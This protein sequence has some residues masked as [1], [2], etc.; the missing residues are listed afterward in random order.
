[1]ALAGDRLWVRELVMQ[2]I[3]TQT[4]DVTRQLRCALRPRLTP[5]DLTAAA[6]SVQTNVPSA[7]DWSADLIANALTATD[8]DEQLNTNSE[9]VLQ[10]LRVGWP[11][12]QSDVVLFST[13]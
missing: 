13:C 9:S 8:H 5:S 10:R 7:A 4:S 2:D 6:A 12:L 11:S 3:R 1:L